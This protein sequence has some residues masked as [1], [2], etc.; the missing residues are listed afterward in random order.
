MRT[1]VY[2]K[3]G[4]HRIVSRPAEQW[5]CQERRGEKG[6]NRTKKVPHFDPWH[7]THRDTTRSEAYRQ[8]SAFGPIDD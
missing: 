6:E 4:K 7:D 3:D 8:L 5:A 1:P 2:T